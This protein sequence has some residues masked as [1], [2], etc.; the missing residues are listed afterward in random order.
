MRLSQGRYELR[1][2]IARRRRHSVHRAFDAVEGREVVVKLVDP[3][4]CAGRD[5][6]EEVSLLRREAEILAGLR[7]PGIIPLERIGVDEGRVYIVMPLLRGR[8]LEAEIRERGQIDCRRAAGIALQVARALAHVHAARILHLDIKP[9]NIFLEGSG[10]AGEP[11]AILMDFG[12]SRLNSIATRED[13]AELVGSAGYMSPEQTGI[14]GQPVTPRSD[15]Y[16]LG[17]VLFRMLTGRL[18]FIAD[19]LPALLHKQVAEEPVRPSAV[20]P[21]IPGVLD[22]MVLTLLRKDPGE[23]YLTAEALCEDLDAFRRMGTQGREGTFVPRGARPRGV[24]NLAPPMRGREGELRAFTEV[25]EALPSPGRNVVFIHGDPGSGKTRLAQEYLKL[26]LKRDMLLMSGQCVLWN[27]EKP[28]QILLDMLESFA[29]TLGRYPESQRA[30]F[31]RGI[32][33]DGA[34][35]RAF[36]EIIADLRR[37]WS[38]L[39]YLTHGD[40]RS[41]QEEIFAELADSLE[42]IARTTGGIVVFVDDVHWCDEVTLYFLGYLA[43][44]A[45]GRPLLIVGTYCPERVDAGGEFTNLL[46]GLAVQEGRLIDRPLA[47][48]PPGECRLVVADVLCALPD[49]VPSDVFSAVCRITKGNPLFLLEYLKWAVDA[50]VLACREAAWRMDAARGGISALPGT[51]AEILSGRV[52]ALE[53]DARMVL[54]CASVLGQRF[55]LDLLS[56]LCGKTAAELLPLLERAVG[57][58]LVMERGPVEGGG[59]MFAHQ[60]VFDAVYR[61]IPPEERRRLHEA[62]GAAL[63]ERNLSDLDRVAFELSNHFHLGYGGKKAFRYMLRAAALARSR[64]ALRDMAY[65]LE[66]ARSLFPGH[67]TAE[68]AAEW[69]EINRRLGEAYLRLGDYDTAIVRFQEARRCSRDRREGAVLRSYIGSVLFRKGSFIDSLRFHEQ[70]LREFGCAP[71]SNRAAVAAAVGFRLLLRAARSAFPRRARTRGRRRDDP[72]VS[73]R[74][75]LFSQASYVYFFLGD[76]ARALW[77][78]LHQLDA[79]ERLGRSEHLAQACNMHGLIMGHVG[80]FRRAEKFIERSRA[81]NEGLVARAWGIAQCQSYL[82]FCLMNQGRVREAIPTLVRAVEIWRG[83]G[84]TLEMGYSLRYLAWSYCY[85]GDLRKASTTF[86]DLVELHRGAGDVWGLAS[87]W[88]GKAWAAMMRGEFEE[89]LDCCRRSLAISSVPE[90]ATPR[91]IA[92]KISGSVFFAMGDLRRAEMELEASRILIEANRLISPAHS[93]T[94]ALLAEVYLADEARAAS[95]SVKERRA[96]RRLCLRGLAQAGRIKRFRAES[97]RSLALYH[98]RYGGDRR[99]RALFERAASIFQV[100]GYAYELA[101]TYR[102]YGTYLLSRGSPSA[103]GFLQRALN[104]FCDMAAAREAEVTRRTLGAK[105]FVGPGSA[106]GPGAAAPAPL[107]DAGALETVLDLSGRVSRILDLDELLV[108]IVDLAN[109]AVGAERGF[110]LLGEEGGFRVRVA[111][112]NARN[113]IEGGDREISWGIV[114]RV[115]EKVEPILIADARG[116]AEWKERESIRALG[117]R[118]VACVPMLDDQAVR[119]I[120]YVENRAIRGL[121]TRRHQNLLQLFAAHA[122]IA[123]RNAE[124]YERLKIAERDAREENRRLKREFTITHRPEGIVGEDPALRAVLRQVV[125]I[126][127][128]DLNVLILGET[129]TG[130]GMVARAIHAASLRAD[131]VFVAQNCANLPETLLESELFGH[132]MGA[133]TGASQHKKGLLEVAD[134]GTLFLDEIAEASPSIQAKLL[135]VIEGQSFRRLGENVERRVDVRIIAATNRA[136]ADEVAAGRFRADLYYRLNGMTLSLPPLRDRKADI[137][138][139]AGYFLNAV[140]RELGK[141]VRGIAPRAMAAIAAYPFPGN[142]RELENEMRKAVILTEPDAMVDLDVLS[143]SIRSGLPEE[144]EVGLPPAYADRTVKEAVRLFEEGFIRDVVSECGGNLTLAARKLGISRSGLYNKLGTARDRAA[145]SPDPK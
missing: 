37:A 113:S 106:S 30:H 51:L 142:V 131:R 81:I 59:Y 49:E 19:S 82:G 104:L 8:T 107:A 46:A 26:C 101:R 73:E 52:E 76:L 34:A 58:Q 98:A 65:Y 112:D 16:S 43:H 45:A 115:A 27:R 50:G 71:P 61:S 36:T 2:E 136:L 94:Y 33:A 70:A 111:R 69:I 35:G 41:I 127:P 91:A 23:R 39:T 126:A 88:N 93:M 42:A 97:S 53:P 21:S 7:H 143:P 95:P 15:L 128:T 135:Q 44:R 137:P 139:L 77:T 141:T 13:P 133:F 22:E 116:D 100:Q 75:R 132:R 17:I 89:A 66:R 103:V 11:A 55:T 145:E 4:R 40:P 5:L 48:L 121:F 54:S 140:S 12:L 57:L 10:P 92:H 86:D 79:A 28:G 102:L 56:S 6:M 20:V 29:E 25:L 123:L 90:L 96:V 108:H 60:Q 80:R 74:I 110:L 32:R 9:G 67:R 84:D 87:A 118:S 83:V 68:D 119:G 64:C 1:E 105:A 14:L 124:L 78:N 138:I 63:E 99:A 47:P 24:L 122:A 130:K 120:I 125:Q 117:L 62:A 31:L 144:A 134:G 109:Q 72:S 85:L 38:E 3:G 18:P 129:G 114:R